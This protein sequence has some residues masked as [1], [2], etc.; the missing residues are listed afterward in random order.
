[1]TLRRE[2]R[3]L[4]VGSTYDVVNQYREGRILFY[5]LAEFP[6]YSFVAD[7]FAPLDGPD[8]VEIMNQRYDEEVERMDRELRDLVLET[9]NQPA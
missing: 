4:S 2:I 5:D 8:E 6:K 3:I 7:A 9:E 1:M